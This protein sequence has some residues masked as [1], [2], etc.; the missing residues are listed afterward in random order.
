VSRAPYMPLPTHGLARY[1]IAR[2]PK[3]DG[4]YP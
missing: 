3:A 4:R 1:A 2:S